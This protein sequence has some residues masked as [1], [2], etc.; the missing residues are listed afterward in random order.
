MVFV[1]REEVLEAKTGVHGQRRAS[2]TSTRFKGGPE[3]RGSELVE[4]ALLCSA[5]GGRGNK[6]GSD[7]E[8]ESNEANGSEHVAERR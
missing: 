3:P 6:W 2:N 7:C 5:V 8:C 4:A 1:V